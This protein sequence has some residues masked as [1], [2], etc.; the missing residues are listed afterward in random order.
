[1]MIRQKQIVYNRTIRA[2][3]PQYIVIHDTGNTSRGANAESHFNYFNTGSRGASADF[4][5]DSTQ[6][7]QVN[8]YTRFYTWHCGDGGGRFGITNGN[9]VGIEICVNS[10]G[11]YDTALKYAAELTKRLMNEL[12]ISPECVVRHYDASRKNCP[13]SMSRNNWEKWYEFKRRLQNEEGFTVTQ[14]EELKEMISN[15][16]AEITKLKNPMI[17]DYIDENMPNWARPTIAKLVEKGILTGDA[18]GKLMLDGN[19]LRMLV[20]NDRAGLYD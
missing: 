8:D 18:E 10:D 16:T 14:Y 13:S 7:L 17:Y 12:H 2:E 15:L 9:S 6:V 1:M 11:I 3:K 19:M 4:F 20:I 5:V